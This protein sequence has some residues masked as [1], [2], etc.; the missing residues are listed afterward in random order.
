MKRNNFL[1]TALLS[2]LLFAGCNK[3]NDSIRICTDF[4]ATVVAD[5]AGLVIVELDGGQKFYTAG[6]LNQEHAELEEGDRLYF[7]YFEINYDKQP[8]SASGSKNNPYEITQLIYEPMD[9]YKPEAKSEETDLF[10]N[11]K[12][13][14]FY[15]PYLE[16]T[17]IDRNYLNFTF[18]IPFDSKPEFKLVYNK[19]SQDTLFYDFKVNLTQNEANNRDATYIETFEMPELPQKGYLHLTFYS[20]SYD[21]RSEGFLS[22]SVFLLPFQLNSSN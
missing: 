22:D 10:P 19:T 2:L 9:V 11:D 3:D 17:T 1:I 5:E 21:R 15:A 6:L 13:R 7:R 8:E 14:F 18:V 16:Q 12:L 20:N 4:I